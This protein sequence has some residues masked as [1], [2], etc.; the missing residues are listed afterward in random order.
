MIGSNTGILLVAS[1]SVLLFYLQAT[2][3]SW[4]MEQM[5]DYQLQPQLIASRKCNIGYN[6]KSVSAIV[7][8]IG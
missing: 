1:F 2:A 4:A 8:I 3:S 6:P 5:V 7:A